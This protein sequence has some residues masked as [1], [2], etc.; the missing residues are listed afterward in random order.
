[1]TQQQSQD[2]LRQT[3]SSEE[4]LR[5]ENLQLITQL[6]QATERLMQQDSAAKQVKDKH[7]AQLQQIESELSTYVNGLKAQH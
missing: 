4:H 7:Q 6:E 5:S 2:R 3:A 1:M